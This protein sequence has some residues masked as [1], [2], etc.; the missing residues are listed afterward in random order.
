MCFQN[1]SKCHFGQQT[2]FP[3]DPMDKPRAQRKRSLRFEPLLGLARRECW[4]L[5]RLILGHEHHLLF[6]HCPLNTEG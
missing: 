6:S 5:Y 2:E 1:Q 4:C 3:L